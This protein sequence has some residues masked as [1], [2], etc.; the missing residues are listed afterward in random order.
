MCKILCLALCCRDVYVSPLI[1][2]IYRH[3]HVL[4]HD[5]EKV[6]EIQVNYR[7]KTN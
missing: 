7:A 2:E 6:I 3:Q 4:K 1:T 5:I